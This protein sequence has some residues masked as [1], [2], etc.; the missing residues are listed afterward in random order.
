MKIGLIIISITAFLVLN[1]YYDGK[2]TKLFHINKKYIQMAT[3]AFVGLSLYLFVKRNPEGSK[4]IFKH[5]NEIVRY[6]PI[7]KNTSDMLTPIFNFADK[8][9][10][11]NVSIPG[12]E[13]MTPQMKRMLN[14]GGGTTKRSVS[15][16]KKKYVA[17][18]QNWKCGKCQEQLKATFQ[19]DHK[20]DLRYGGSNHVTN[21]VALCT[22]CHAQKTM[23]SNL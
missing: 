11:R 22:E 4:S 19:V 16:T 15:E 12:I 2:Y 21:L 18:S 5:A 8:H 14:S 13:T 23:E 7:D 20:I 9:Q 17:S 10:N 3:Y 6:M 1:T